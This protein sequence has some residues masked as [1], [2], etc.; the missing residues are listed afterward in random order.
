M[1]QPHLHLEVAAEKDAP[2]A[3]RCAPRGWVERPV[4]GLRVRR[5]RVVK[6]CFLNPHK[7]FDLP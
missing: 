1:P 2:S 7:I 6:P 5:P 3:R 4:R